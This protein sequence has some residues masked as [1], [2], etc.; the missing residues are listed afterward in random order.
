MASRGSQ[1]APAITAAMLQRTHF[2]RVA[3]D[4]RGAPMG[5][6]MPAPRPPQG[7]PV[8]GRGEAVVRPALSPPGRAGRQVGRFARLSR[9]PG[10]HRAAGLVGSPAVPRHPTPLWLADLEIWQI[11]RVWGLASPRETSRKNI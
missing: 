2:P 3:G 9:L 5:A 6:A 10:P 7:G 8:R 11:W 4:A 1:C